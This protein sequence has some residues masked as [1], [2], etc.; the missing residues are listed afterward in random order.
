MLLSRNAVRA[1][2]QGINSIKT[3]DARTESEDARRSDELPSTYSMCGVLLIYYHKRA[4]LHERWTHIQ[5][6]GIVGTS[7]MCVPSY[8]EVADM[9]C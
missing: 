6:S 3:S 5:C 7:E 4:Q 1:G 9:L 8:S 2:G